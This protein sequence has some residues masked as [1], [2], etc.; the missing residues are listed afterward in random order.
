MGRREFWLQDLPFLSLTSRW[1]LEISS[2]KTEIKSSGFQRRYA[3]NPGIIPI[4]TY[5]NNSLWGQRAPFRWVR[6]LHYHRDGPDDRR[7]LGWWRPGA[8]LADR[9][10]TS[11]QQCLKIW[12][13]MV[14]QKFPTF[15]GDYGIA[16]LYHGNLTRSNPHVWTKI[17]ALPQFGIPARADSEILICL[18]ILSFCFWELPQKTVQVWTFFP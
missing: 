10:I 13:P 5:L 14:P 17:D 16:G 15:M 7:R 3:Q 11:D 6:W 18:I 9:R 1:C 2:P 4:S 12:Y 8:D